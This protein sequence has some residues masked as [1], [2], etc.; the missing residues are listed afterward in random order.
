MRAMQKKHKQFVELRYDPA[1]AYAVFSSVQTPAVVTLVEDG[2][3]DVVAHIVWVKDKTS[4][5]M[6]VESAEDL[7]DVL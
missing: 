5:T 6:R 1:N 4:T 2:R 7:A 3:R